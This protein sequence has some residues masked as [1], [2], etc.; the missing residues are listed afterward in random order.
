[1]A[2]KDL[3]DALL[4]EMRDMLSAEKQLTRA[5][6]KMARK[7]SDEDLRDG[8]ELHLEET[9][10]QIELLEQAFDE[11]EQKPRS[12][13][14]DGIAGIIDEAEHHIEEAEEGEA[15][16]AVLI[17][18]AQK[19]EHYEIASYGTMCT[20]AK[21]LGFEKVEKLLHQILEQEKA[22]DAKLTDMA[23]TINQE[24]QPA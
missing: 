5:L 17:A 22:T 11:L 2:V 7:A 10:G 16:D 4:N 1:M 13:H 18:A 24:A 20:W 15:L 23:M 3:H 14:C 12:K 6:K 9:Q 19:A 21:T 8:F